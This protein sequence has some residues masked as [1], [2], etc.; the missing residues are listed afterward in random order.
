MTVQIKNRE[1]ATVVTKNES[2]ILENNK[3]SNFQVLFSERRMLLVLGDTL[4][5]VLAVFGAFLL[6]HQTANTGL[7]VAPYI[8]EHW[9]WF[10]LLLGGWWVL[11]WFNDLYDISSAFDKIT[12][13]KRVAVV[14][15]MNLIIC[16]LVFS[17]SN[18]PFRSFFL[19]FPVIVWPA[20][21]LWR[22]VYAT[23]LVQPNFQRRALIMGTG[24]TAR[25]IAQAIKERDPGYEIVGYV[26]GDASEQE[27]DIQ[28]VS[29]LGEWANLTK[30][31]QEYGVSDIILAT[32]R[33]MHA[34][35]L[36][37]VLKC[38]EQGVRIVPMSKLF[39]EITGRI[40]VEHIG[41]RW[42]VSLPID[43]DSRGLYLIVK[44]AMDIVIAG[45]GLLFLLPF[46]PLLVLAI[47]LD[48]PGPIFYRAERLGQGGKPFTVVKFRTMV[49]NADR[50]GDPTFTARN[51][52]RITRVGRILRTTHID[53]LPQLINVIAG[54]MSLVGPRPER[55]VPEL[56]E[57]IPYYRTRYAVKPGATGWA[58]VKQGYAE[59][60]EDTLIKLQY[61]L[62][63]IKHQSL[64]FDILILGKS[65]IHMLTMGGR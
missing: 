54:E 63:Y 57:S 34:D 28:G 7:D 23:M 8:R 41:E 52:R 59:G 25:T 38:F 37:A 1:V 47:E 55:Y 20:M 30:L 35:Q 33:D 49:L 24:W 39:E 13:S 56:E 27:K 45:I 22:I 44:R 6:W 18:N 26:A 12:S 46:F 10:P 5:V 17:L 61:D 48:S 15:V 40:P 3:Y 58:L 14:G 51:D 21:S 50:I 32:I 16:L 11:A 64:F 4:V 53:E 19:Y 62:Y 60:L 36:Q 2:A 43:W 29:V 31:V 65:V 42:L 9:H